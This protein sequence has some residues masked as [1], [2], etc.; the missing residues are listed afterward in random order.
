M[1]RLSG[2]TWE[3]LLDRERRIALI[4]LG[5]LQ[6]GT[7]EELQAAFAALKENAAK[8]L[9]LDLRDCPGGLLDEATT[10]VQR[11]IRGGVVAKIKY[12]ADEE[13]VSVFSRATT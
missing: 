3:Y 2:G 5:N 7:A 12:R 8:G 4:R 13:T 11:F 6:D 1:Q 9:I 10:I